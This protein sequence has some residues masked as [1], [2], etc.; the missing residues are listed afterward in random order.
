MPSRTIILILIAL[1]LATAWIAPAQA[2]TA[3]DPLH[4]ALH[5]LLTGH[6]HDDVESHDHD[7]LEVK[8]SFS[9]SDCPDHDKLTSSEHHH[10]HDASFSAAL[11]SQHFKST[12]TGSAVQNPR[13]LP[14]MH[15]AE[16]RADLRPPLA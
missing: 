14:A 13:P 7:G 5:T 6:H 9:Y 10:H 3:A 2:S 4:R 16:R 8:E 15:S 1:Q 11:V 12:I